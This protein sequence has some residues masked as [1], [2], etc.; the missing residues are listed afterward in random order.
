MIRSIEM[1]SGLWLLVDEGDTF[2]KKS[3]FFKYLSY[4]KDLDVRHAIDGMHVQKNVF[5]S[6][7]DQPYSGSS[8][9]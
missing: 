9:W 1:V 6:S 4:W 5:E 3:I 7:P 2:K 8:R